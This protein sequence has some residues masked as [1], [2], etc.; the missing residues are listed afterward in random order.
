MMRHTVQIWRVREGGWQTVSRPQTYQQAQ[1]KIAKLQKIL[2]DSVFRL[3][4]LEP[5]LPGFI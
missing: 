2:P 4:V 1:Q 5:Q 3:E